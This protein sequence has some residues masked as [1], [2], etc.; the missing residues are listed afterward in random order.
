MGNGKP[1][2]L[3]SWSMTFNSFVFRKDGSNCCVENRLED[4]NLEIGKPFIN[5]CC[6]NPGKS[7]SDLN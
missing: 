6:N 3:L 2:E 4:T 1:L 7:D 5:D